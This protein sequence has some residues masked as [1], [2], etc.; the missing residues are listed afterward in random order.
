MEKVFTVTGLR[1]RRNTSITKFTQMDLA[2]LD[3]RMRRRLI[4]NK[5]FKD[6]SFNCVNLL[7]LFLKNIENASRINF[8]A[9]RYCAKNLSVYK[10]CLGGLDVQLNK[11]INDEASTHGNVYR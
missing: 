7:T 8:V 5:N 6:M 11:Y 9:A 4:K 1:K 2:P 10:H 3:I